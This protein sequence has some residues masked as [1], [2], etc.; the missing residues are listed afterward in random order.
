MC[1]AFEGIWSETFVQALDERPHVKLLA[2]VSVV[3][4]FGG[5]SGS[6]Q[7]LFQCVETDLHKRAH[8]LQV[9]TFP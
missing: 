2:S 5:M 6:G 4:L 9:R 7:A 1:V 3:G 8:Q